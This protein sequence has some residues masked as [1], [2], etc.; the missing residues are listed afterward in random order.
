ML[1]QLFYN[2]LPTNTQ[3]NVD[4]ASGGAI[5]N[6]TPDEAYDLLEV[7]ANNNYLKN[8]R[9][10]TQKDFAGEKEQIFLINRTEH[11]LLAE[12]VRCLCVG[13]DVTWGPPCQALVTRLPANRRRWAESNRPTQNNSSNTSNTSNTIHNKFYMVR[14]E[15]YVHR[16][17]K[18]SI[19]IGKEEYTL[20]ISLLSWQE[21]KKQLEMR[22]ENWRPEI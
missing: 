9:C 1:V 14:R 15:A 2:G 11:P 4:A 17:S 18:E 21:K 20:K 3:L 13:C 8:D 22:L 10:L 5:N 7:M 16:R 6:K 12:R 19:F